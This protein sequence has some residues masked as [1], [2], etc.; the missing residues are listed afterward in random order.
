MINCEQCPFFCGGVFLGFKC[1]KGHAADAK[2]GS[3]FMFLRAACPDFR[4][5]TQAEQIKRRWRFAKAVDLK[6][7]GVAVK[8]MV[9]TLR[10]QASEAGLGQYLSSDE[11]ADLRAAAEALSRIGKNM[12]LAARMLKAE[13]LAQAEASRRE[14]IAA[15][16]RAAKLIFHEVSTEELPS[17]ALDLSA[18]LCV[19]H[20][21][22]SGSIEHAANRLRDALKQSSDPAPE[23][24]KA[25]FQAVGDEVRGFADGLDPHRFNGNHKLTIA[26]FHAFREKQIECR[27][28]EEAAKN[29]PNVVLLKRS[30]SK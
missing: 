27:R 5:I 24:T 25:L 21:H 8:R 10:N 30:S 28:V 18:F 17:V 11:I 26:E 23:L 22:R 15:C 13:E 16:D 20:G 3:R 14:N 1:E 6:N 19:K 7:R 2:H 29:S 4:V 12:E 9:S